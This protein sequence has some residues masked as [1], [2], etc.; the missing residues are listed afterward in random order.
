MSSSRNSLDSPKNQSLNICPC[1]NTNPCTSKRT[2]ISEKSSITAQTNRNRSCCGSSVEDPLGKIR[3]LKQTILEHKSSPLQILS[4]TDQ[5]EIPKKSSLQASSLQPPSIST[6]LS[7]NNSEP[8]EDEIVV[9]VED[10][11]YDS[12]ENSA[13]C[14]CSC[15]ECQCQ[16]SNT[17]IDQHNM[18]PCDEQCNCSVTNNLLNQLPDELLQNLQN[19]S[20]S[21]VKIS[22]KGDGNYKLLFNAK[23]NG[24]HIPVI[25][26]GAKYSCDYPKCKKVYACKTALRRHKLT[27]H[28]KKR[29]FACELCSLTFGL[30]HHLK[31][32]I[33][34]VHSDDR[35]Y[36]CEFDTCNKAFKTRYN[37]KVHMRTHTGE[38]PFKC[39]ECSK[40]FVQKSVLT[41]HQKTHTKVFP[42]TKQSQTEKVHLIENP[43]VDPAQISC[44]NDIFIPP[45]AKNQTLNSARQ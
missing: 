26:S 40:T 34:Q 25:K 17:V 9:N 1:C 21:K 41:I 19:L 32:H 30:Q 38:R 18:C 35:P 45:D 44:E 3:L 12:I 29:N 5:M 24:Q 6:S 39:V 27:L 11:S 37:L 43:P 10:D 23:L 20:F 36:V 4:T 33:E 42:T 8:I 14:C 2:K 31:R 7:T 15:A 28:E 22:K 13:S 16:V